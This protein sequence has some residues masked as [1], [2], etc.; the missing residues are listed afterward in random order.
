MSKIHHA[1][2]P[3]SPLVKK[4]QLALVI[5]FSMFALSIIG[6]V[7]R[8]IYNS[9]VWQDVFSASI[10]ISLIA[11]PIFLFLLSL[12]NYVFWGITLGREEEKK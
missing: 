2:E 7:A 9:W 3:D 8:L 11:V 12:F 10:A 5:G 4:L 6:W 1:A